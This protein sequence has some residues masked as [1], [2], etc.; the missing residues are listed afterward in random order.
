MMATAER[1]TQLSSSLKLLNIR[2]KLFP[3][4]CTV[5]AKV[6]ALSW[7]ALVRMYSTQAMSRSSH[8]IVRTDSTSEDLYHPRGGNTLIVSHSTVF[9]H[10][11]RFFL[12]ILPSNHIE[13]KTSTLLDERLMLYP[14]SYRSNCSCSSKMEYD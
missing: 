1:S 7:V 6:N 3:Q 8:F 4:S 5:N 11:K 9:F 10:S 2:R 12:L 13:I 14:L